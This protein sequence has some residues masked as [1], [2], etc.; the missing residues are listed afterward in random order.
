VAPAAEISPVRVRLIRPLHLV[1]PPHEVRPLSNS[2]Y[3]R[4][5]VPAA[6]SFRRSHHGGAIA[7]GLEVP[8]PREAGPP[9][10]RRKTPSAWNADAREV[11][12][13]LARMDV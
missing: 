2:D 7:V 11:A 8:L 9:L 5:A 4:L 6:A 3:L 1:D 12:V 10:G 13:G